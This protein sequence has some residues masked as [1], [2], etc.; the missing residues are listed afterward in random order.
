MRMPGTAD[1]CPI[2]KNEQARHRSP[3]PYPFAFHTIYRS[4]RNG[5]T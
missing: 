1:E 5:K 2:R 4:T 3:V